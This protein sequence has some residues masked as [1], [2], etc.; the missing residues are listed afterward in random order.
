[1]VF[2]VLITAKLRFITLE[3]KLNDKIQPC[4]LNLNLKGRLYELRES[5]SS[6][7][8]AFC[9]ISNLILLQPIRLFS[10]VLW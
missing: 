8:N 5:L 6:F 9:D 2:L 4:N 7:Y 1:M 10:V 3:A